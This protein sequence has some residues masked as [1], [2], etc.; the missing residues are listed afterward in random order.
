MRGRV[1]QLLLLSLGSSVLV[2]WAVVGAMSIGVLLL[3]AAVV[4]LVAASKTSELVSAA[5]AWLAVAAGAVAALVLAVA[6]FGFS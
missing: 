6:V 4:S 2:I 5:S 1:V 3:P